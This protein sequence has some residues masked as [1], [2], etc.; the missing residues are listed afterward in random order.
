MGVRTPTQVDQR[1]AIYW[2]FEN[3]HASLIENEQGE[4]AYRRS[5]YRPQ[6]AVVQ[7]APIVNH[8][9]SFGDIVL[10]RAYGNW[11]WLGRYREALLE[12]SIDLVQLFPRGAH[13]KNGADIRLAL[14]ALDDC[15]RYPQI[16]HVVI[17]SGD[18]DYISVAQKLRQAGTFVIGI[19]VEG[20]SNSFWMRSCNAFRFYGSLLEHTVRGPLDAAPVATGDGSAKSLLQTAVRD[21]SRQH[22]DDWVVKAA[23][24]PMMMRLDAAFDESRHGYSTFPQFIAA[25]SD[26]LEFRQGQHDHEVRL[27]R[28]PDAPIAEGVRLNPDHPTSATALRYARILDDQGIQAVDATWRAAALPLVVRAFAAVPDQIHT[29]WSDVTRSIQDQLINAGLSSNDPS[30]VNKLRRIAFKA[31]AFRYHPDGGISLED[32]VDENTLVEA[33]MKMLIERISSTAAPP[34]DEEALCDLIYGAG[35]PDRLHDVHELVGK[36]LSPDALLER[37]VDAMVSAL[38]TTPQE[39]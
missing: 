17:V 11:Q 18:S 4:G 8:A 12:Q 31:K 19:G 13:A 7:F 37:Q 32:W 28:Q 39:R 29:G 3:I 16:S 27:R 24:Q 35:H 38:S 15:L 20:A 33:V 34:L 10:N 5:W 22:G 6:E 21:L 30:M 26:V 14:D 9:A 2:D 23:I 25:C 1:V 36:T